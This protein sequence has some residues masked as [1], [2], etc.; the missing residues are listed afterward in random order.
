MIA[1]PQHEKPIPWVGFCIG[2]SLH[3]QAIPLPS[4]PPAGVK[5]LT[6]TAKVADAA[7]PPE[8]YRIGFR[9]IEAIPVSH[10]GRGGSMFAV[11]LFGSD[12]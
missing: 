11:M 8:R 4:K 1:S 10:D 5:T 6:L 12:T 7:A 9:D 3:G 2:G